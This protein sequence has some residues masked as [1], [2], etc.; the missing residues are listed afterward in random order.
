[1]PVSLIE[2]KKQNASR[3]RKFYEKNRVT[4][5]QKNRDDRAFIRNYRNPQNIQPEPVM[6][7][8]TSLSIPS[9]IEGEIIQ[10]KTDKAQYI[11]L[12]YKC[13]VI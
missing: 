13:K 4:I 11:I 12:R 5:L 8:Q 2:K 6:N 3:Q 7:K 10:W 9:L 1:M